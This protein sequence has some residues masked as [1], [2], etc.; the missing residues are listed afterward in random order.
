MWGG[1]K[2]TLKIKAEE[3]PQKLPSHQASLQLAGAAVASQTLPAPTPRSKPCSLLQ[4]AEA[5]HGKVSPI[6]IPNGHPPSS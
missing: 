4:Q 5:Q 6:T 3:V 2:S 1:G